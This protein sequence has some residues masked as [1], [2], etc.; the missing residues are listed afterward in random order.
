MQQALLPT[1]PFSQPSF[2]FKVLKFMHM[3]D[4]LPVCL[5]AMCVQ[6]LWGLGEGMRSPGTDLTVV[7]HQAY[8]ALE[9]EP[10]TSGRESSSL[11]GYCEDSRH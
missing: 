3:G 4:F 10:R 8:Q 2:F 1:E 11:T 9:V 7:S 6:C 5:C